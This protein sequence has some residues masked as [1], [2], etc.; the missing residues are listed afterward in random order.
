M[1]R[2]GGRAQYYPLLH[3]AFWV[4][5]RLWGDATLGYHLVNILLHAAAA[6][7]VALLLRRLSVPGSYLAAA[8]FAL[9]PVHVESVAWITEQKNTLSAVFYWGAM[10]VY[11][12]FDQARKTRR[13][14][15]RWPCSSWAC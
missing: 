4:E 1:V 14:A 15:G 10:L 13:I 6:V 8:I 3:S 5:H 2:T 11:L 9:H 12:R 7:M